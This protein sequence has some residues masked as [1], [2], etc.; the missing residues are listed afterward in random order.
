MNNKK[1][2]VIV[3]VIAVIAVI[4]IAGALALFKPER[5]LMQGEVDATAVKISSKLAGRV[6]QLFVVKGQK[7]T[8]GT[9]LFTLSTPEV[10]AKHRQALAAKAGAVAQY[11]KAEYGARK[12]TIESAY[13]LWQKAIAGLELAQK[14]YD[15]VKNLFE[16]GVVPA[17][18]MDEAA[19]NLKAMQSTAHAAKLQYELA[20]E[21]AQ[22]EDK[23][24]AKSMVDRAEGAVEE[25]ESYL[26]DSEQFSPIDGEVSSIIAE[27]GELVGSGYPILSIIDINNPWISFNVKETL[28]PK[29]KVGTKFMAYFPALDKE[30]ELVVSEIAVQAQYATWSAT[31]STG[32]FD[33]RTFE[34]IARPVSKVE[35][36]RIGMTTV[37]DLDKIK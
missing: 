26:S 2:F 35:D 15:R 22:K 10:T 18:K 37:V 27:Q 5:N 14:S 17:Q 24:A 13:S 30:Y 34:V 23:A 21:G 12:Q 20:K 3:V 25:V 19:A 36:I 8:K 6:E 29:L 9:P 31:R 28:L 4:G 7:V 11:D 1:V 33:I 16:S 32:A